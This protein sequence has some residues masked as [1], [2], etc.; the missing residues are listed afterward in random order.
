MVAPAVVAPAVV[1]PAVVA[2]LQMK[3]GNC[4]FVNVPDNLRKMFI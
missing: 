2:P 3:T 1:A 4:F